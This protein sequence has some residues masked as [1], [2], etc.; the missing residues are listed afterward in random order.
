MKHV[1]FKYL[2][3]VIGKKVPGASIG[4]GEINANKLDLIMKQLKIH[5]QPS[6]LM[7][8]QRRVPAHNIVHS[9]SARKE[10]KTALS[11]R[12]ITK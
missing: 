12:N 1:R 5:P 10:I 8:F 3:Y 2:V 6:F 4:G 9:T 7:K 11:S